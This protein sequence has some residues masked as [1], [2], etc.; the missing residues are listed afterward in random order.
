MFLSILAAVIGPVWPQLRRWEGGHGRRRGP[1]P[2]PLP[3][4]GA[5]VAAA[6]EEPGPS[7]GQAAQQHRQ[8]LLA[9]R[10]LGLKRVHRFGADHPA[11]REQ[12][13][14]GQRGQGQRGPGQRLS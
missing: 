12:R 9:T 2:G 6:A 1:A 7:R 8:A 3:I 13:G 10:D 5:A 11:D 14:Q 4:A